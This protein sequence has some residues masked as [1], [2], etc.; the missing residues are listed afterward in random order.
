MFNVLL[1][2]LTAETIDAEVE[3]GP[4]N[5]LLFLVFASIF[6]AIIIYLLIA[7]RRNRHLHTTEKVPQAA[8]IKSRD[9]NTVSTRYRQNG[10]VTA[11]QESVESD[12]K[13]E[14]AF[15]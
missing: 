5:Y 12:C 4:A 13:L 3:F 6:L 8:T 11:K 10:I 15:E 1:Y 2:S 14:D 7:M 9:N